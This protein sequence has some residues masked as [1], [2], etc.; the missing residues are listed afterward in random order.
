MKQLQHPLM[1][2]IEYVRELISSSFPQLIEHIKWNAPSFQLNGEDCLTFNF[3]PNQKT[4]RLV[5]HRGAKKKIQPKERLVTDS[6]EWLQWAANDRAVATFSSLK[7]I[8]A[9][10][11][12]IKAFTEN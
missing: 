5:F 12:S 6:P 2:E 10:K 9:Q 4:I 8:K 1:A 7:D 3:P 11:P